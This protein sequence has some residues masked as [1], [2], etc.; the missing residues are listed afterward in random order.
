MLLQVTRLVGREL[1]HLAV[2]LYFHVYFI[3]MIFQI[4]FGGGFEVAET[5]IE[6]FVTTVLSLYM[7]S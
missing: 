2:I 5:T 4:N 7:N 6:R 1:T 3:Y